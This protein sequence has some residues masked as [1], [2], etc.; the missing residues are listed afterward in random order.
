ML[1]VVGE[2]MI[3]EVPS[4]LS[5]IEVSHCQARDQYGLLQRL[6]LVCG[7]AVCH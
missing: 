3:E 6:D 1:H 5:A 4:V 7:H 2:A